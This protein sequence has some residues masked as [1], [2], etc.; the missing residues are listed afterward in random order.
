MI[1]S[2][3]PIW[4]VDVLGSICMIIL[5]FMCVRLATLLRRR[6]RNNIIWTYLYWFCTAL[7]VF[8]V[9]RSAGHILKQLLI[10]S[11]DAVAWNRIRPY[12]GAI[13]TLTFVV[14][15][16][17]TLFFQRSW[18]IYR[19]IA[20]DKQDLQATRD[21]LLYLNQNLENLV[22][23]R[24]EAL[25]VSEHKYRRIFETSRDM[26]LV[27]QTDGK[28]VDVNPAGRIMLGLQPTDQEPK[29]FRQFFSRASDWR[30]VRESLKEY[31][32]ISNAEIELLCN[33]NRTRT[34]V[35]G[36]LNQGAANKS[37]TIH[38]LVKDIEQKRLTEEQIAQ[39]DKLA[40]IGQL[41]AGIAHEINNPLGIILGYTQLLLRQEG[42]DS[43]KYQDLKTIEKHVRNC[44]GIVEDLLNFARTSPPKKTSIDIAES[45]DEVLRFVRH[46]SNLDNIEVVRD[47]DPQAPP[48]R[49]DEKKIK[50]VF[51]NL[52]MNAAHA[53]GKSGTLWLS[54]RYLPDSEQMTIQFTDSGYGIEE[55]NLS[56]IFDPFF[57]TKPTGEGTGLGLSVSYGIIKNHGGEITVESDVGRGSTFTVRLPYDGPRGETHH[58]AQHSDCR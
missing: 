10:L 3:V 29:N 24:T 12:S 56:R 32:F 39:A 31:G 53:I 55:R 25:A 38:F 43:E 45:L 40:S 19:Q 52:I 15:G 17:I 5:A 42:N 49:L 51:M 7:A 41:S 58:A 47:Y 14:V 26:I 57:T 28:I 22:A 33:Q 9:S 35:S 46:H 13:N 1:T 37:E 54:T 8:A 2:S 4:A 6:D 21:K 36:S 27:A 44:K 18:S 30:T 50:Q 20:S 23:A 34:L 11:G 16:A 48:M